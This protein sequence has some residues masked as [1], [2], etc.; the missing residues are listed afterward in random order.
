MANTEELFHRSY[1]E[2]RRGFVAVDSVTDS[3]TRGLGFYIYY[4]FDLPLDTTKYLVFIP[5]E[6]DIH[7]QNRRVNIVDL[8]NQ[9]INVKINTFADATVNT[10][11]TDISEKI[12]NADLNNDNGI[13]L[14][15]YDDTS[16]VDVSGAVRLP[17]SGTISGDRKSVA[18]TYITN[19]YILERQ[20]PLVV[21]FI[22][23]STQG[24]VRVEYN[25]F[26]YQCEC[27]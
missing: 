8:D 3:V 19:E 6:V 23:N 10:L 13:L 2:G 21:E 15:F 20:E 5:G 18:S 24:D 4:E 12:I 9:L 1:R 14:S 27:E 11:G 25:S 16:D 26:G 22:N 17:F 7:A